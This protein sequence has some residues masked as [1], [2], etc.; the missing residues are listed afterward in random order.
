MLRFST[1]KY[2]EFRYVRTAVFSRPFLMFATVNSSW[3]FWNNWSSSTQ[4]CGVSY[5]Q[6]RS[7]LAAALYTAD[8]TQWTE[9]PDSQQQT[10]TTGQLTAPGAR[11]RPHD[12]TNPRKRPHNQP[13]PTAACVRRARVVEPIEKSPIAYPTPML[14]KKTGINLE[15]A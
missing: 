7:A 6:Q 14:A 4:E 10:D 5:W 9:T 3:K 8:Y 1:N 15:E 13:R 11:L 2:L 12:H